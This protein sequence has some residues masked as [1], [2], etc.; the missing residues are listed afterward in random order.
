MINFENELE[1]IER[2]KMMQA[3][4]YVTGFN[5]CRLMDK[6]GINYKQDLFN[7]PAEG[8]YEIFTKHTIR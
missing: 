8:L 1:F 6:I 2:T 7:H 4:Y 3:Y 5:L